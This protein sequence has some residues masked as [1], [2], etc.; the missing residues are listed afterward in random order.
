ML[1]TLHPSGGLQRSKLDLALENKLRERASLAARAVTAQPA[2]GCT[3]P[4]SRSRVGVGIAVV[5]AT[6]G[7]KDEAAF[8]ALLPFSGRCA[9]RNAK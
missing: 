7:A 4:R 3:H 9:F 5:E 2:R 6:S 1:V 8:D